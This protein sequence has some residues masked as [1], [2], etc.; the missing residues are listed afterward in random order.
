[1]TNIKPEQMRKC[2]EGNS[3]VSKWE[4]VEPCGNR[5]RVCQLAVREWERVRKYKYQHTFDI[6]LTAVWC[7]NS[8]SI[9]QLWKQFSQSIDHLGHSSNKTVKHSL[10]SAPAYEIWIFSVLNDCNLNILAV[11]NSWFDKIRYFNMSPWGL[12]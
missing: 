7:W 1:M 9:D 3:A 11:L 12:C 2:R 6:Y 8:L 5:R 4:E 10:V